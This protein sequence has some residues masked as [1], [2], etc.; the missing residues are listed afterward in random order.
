MPRKVYKQTSFNG[1][2][3]SPLLHSRIDIGKY[4]NS[5]ET[6][7]NS[8]VTPQGPIK[9]RNGS[10]RVYTADSGSTAYAL[11]AFQPDVD[12]SYILEFGDELITIYPKTQ[13][14]ITST[15]TTVVSPYQDTE[16]QDITYVQ[17][18]SVIYLAHPNYAPRK[19]TYTSATVWSLETL[20]FLIPA[21]YEP[22]EEPAFTITPNATTGI[23]KEMYAGLSS[24]RTAS[25]QWTASGSGT[26]E[27]YLEAS[28]G[29]DPSIT[30]PL[31]VIENGSAMTNATLGTLSAGEWDWGDN[32]TLGFSTVYV[33]LSDNTDP[34]SKAVDYV[35][36]TSASA[37][38]AGDTGRQVINDNGNG[39]ASI[40][41][42]DSAAKVTVD[43]LEDFDDTSSI[44]SGD[45]YLDLSPISEL[46]P[47]GSSPGAIITITSDDLD[48]T[49][50]W[51]TFRSTDVGKYIKLNSGIVQII[52]VTD[53][54]T[55][56]AEVLKGLTSLDE[57]S[58]WTLEDESWDATRGYPRAVSLYQNRLWFGGTVAQPQTIWASETGLFDKFG[59]GTADDDAIE[60]T[61][62][63]NSAAQINWMVAAR[64][65][66]V[67]TSGAEHTVNGG[68]TGVAITP[69][70]ISQI[71]RTYYGSDTQ[72]PLTVGS[73][74]LFISKSKRKIRSFRYDF[75]IDGYVSEDLLFLAEHLAD[76]DIVQI[77]YASEPFSQIFAV[78]S[79]G[80]MLACSYVR[81]QQVL[82]WSKY[83][84]D[85]SFKYSQ[86]ISNGA[87]D[88]VWCVVERDTNGTD[89]NYIET[90]V[91]GE[92]EDPADIFSDNSVIITGSETA[93]T[94]ITKADPGV[95]TT[96][97]AHGLSNGDRVKLVSVSGMTEVNNT[98]YIVANKTST[99][100]ELTTLQ[101][102]NVDTTSY[103]TYTSGGYV[104][105]LFLTKTDA[106]LATLEAES[107]LSIKVDG[108]VHPTLTVSSN[109]FTLNYYGHEVVLGRS[110]TTTITPL[111][112]NF[113]VGYGAMRSQQQRHVNFGIEVYK[114]LPP[115]INGINDPL[116]S[117]ADEMDQPLPLYTGFFK[118]G[119]LGWG[120]SLSTSIVQD[121]PVPL[122]V[123][124]IYSIADGGIT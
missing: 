88:D 42:V 35:Q 55:I 60:V 22:G 95:V 18:G 90:F 40:T 124:G 47:D 51:D 2:E 27:Y 46:T 54:Y 52:S 32:D 17:E 91:A 49:T 111:S 114:S 92:G 36:Q 3:L 99:T 76:S 56:K 69:S 37:F 9:R 64:D 96:G 100:F 83:T 4:D 70:N 59:T 34:D 45:W 6:A 12:T 71:P 15:P 79:N 39:R 14:V 120:N 105:E 68:S 73:E 103:T 67:G 48:T 104:Y 63:S 116:R 29:G 77:S 86:T 102:A 89:T 62:S 110:Y 50:D 44:A 25:F 38:L 94:G 53:A 106:T 26:N 31:E 115:T 81:E 119:E 78:L 82:G 75:N 123:L 80:N 97:T 65:L 23:D 57:T 113:D 84:T 8:F 20:S 61:I 21:L 19:L 66:V 72:N 101:G 74:V 5:L 33:R 112:Q 93:I 11:V 10:L 87:K 122:V 7:T 121:D 98:T 30:E 28:G 16:V 108:A 109:A 41:S 13:S 24:I 107:N 118:Y 117:S 1:G 85:G 58:D 43:I